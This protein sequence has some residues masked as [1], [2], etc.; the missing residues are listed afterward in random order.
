MDALFDYAMQLG[1]RVEFT[2]LSY[3]NRNGDYCH[4]LKLIRLQDGMQPRKTRHTFAHELGHA[5]LGDEPSI[6]SH[7]HQRQEDRA[8]EWAAHF[9]IAPADFKDV[10]QRHNSKIDAMASDLYVLER[11]VRAY[12]RTL[13]RLGDRLYVHSRMGEGQWTRRFEVAQ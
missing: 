6:L 5:T 13:D 2:D 7:V 9:L 11:T 10:E 12:V 1:V 3:L 4:E 8:D